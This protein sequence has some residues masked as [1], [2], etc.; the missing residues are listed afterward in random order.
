MSDEEAKGRRAAAR[1]DAP[2]I[3]LVYLW[4]DL[5]DPAFRAKRAAAMREAHLVVNEGDNGACRYQ[6]HDELK[7]SLRSA[8][9]FAPWLRLIHVVIDDDIA[10]PAWL[11]VSSPRLRIH[12][13]GEIMPPEKLPCFNSSAMEFFLHEIPGLSERFLYANDDMMFARPVRPSFFFGRDG[14]PVFRYMASRIDMDAPEIA[15]GYRHRVRESFRFAVR[16]FGV[17][18]GYARAFGHLSHHNIDAYVKS[19]LAAFRA[20]FPDVW[21]RQTSHRF[22]SRDQL[23]REVFAGFAFSLGH[24]HFRQIRRPWWETVLG[25]PHRDSWHCIPTKDDIE[26]EFRRIKPSL[27]CMND[28]P[29]VTPLGRESATRFLERHFPAKSE[30]EL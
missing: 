21:E 11:D 23:Q 22:R 8:G 24:A 13:W 5:A 7:Y 1:A 28:S 25:L 17:R 29:E 30:F 16:T 18:H 2:E 4:C 20:A 6:S 14:W 19:D 15:D 9:M 3:D 12:R 26:R 10:P 27:V